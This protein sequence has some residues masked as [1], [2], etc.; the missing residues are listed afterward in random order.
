MTPK[1]E[2]MLYAISQGGDPNEMAKLSELSGRGH[3]SFSRT[4]MALYRKGY[5]RIAKGGGLEITESGRAAAKRG[6]K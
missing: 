2:E 3:A 1:Q 6:S 4:M 5:L